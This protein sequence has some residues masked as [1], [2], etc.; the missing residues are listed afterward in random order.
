MKAPRTYRAERLKE[1]AYLARF[2]GPVEFVRQVAT[3]YRIETA[4]SERR[5]AGG[6]K[7]HPAP[8]MFQGVPGSQAAL[9]SPTS[10]LDP[11]DPD[12]Q[13]QEMIDLVASQAAT[14][15]KLQAELADA[16]QILFLAHEALLQRKDCSRGASEP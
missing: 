14:I 13:S 2:L 10:G 4:Y 1:L 7:A 9:P 6:P 15:K 11:G 5:N 8:L 16:R 3:R 12:E